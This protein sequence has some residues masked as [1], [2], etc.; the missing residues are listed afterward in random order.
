MYNNIIVIHYCC[1]SCH[2]VIFCRVKTST[3]NGTTYP[4]K[5]VVVC[6][7]EDY[8]PVFGVIE[9]IIVTLSQECLFVLKLL[10]THLNRHFHCFEVQDT[11]S[12]SFVCRHRDL[13]DH[14]PLHLCQ[15]FGPGGKLCLCLK[16]HIIVEK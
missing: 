14:Y 12:H 9:D 16:Y 3:V 2:N 15:Q 1:Y 6:G 8:Q 11:S 5:A 10:I 13:V 7:F 4:K